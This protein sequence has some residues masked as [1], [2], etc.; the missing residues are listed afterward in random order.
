LISRAAELVVGSGARALLPDILSSHGAERVLVVASART[1]ASPWLRSLLDGFETHWFCG[2]TPNPSLEQALAGSAL[3]ERRSPDAVV[4]VGGGSAIDTAKLLRS[5]PPERDRALELL[6]GRAEPPPERPPLVALPTTAGTGSEVT[7]FATLYVDRVKASLDHSTVAPDDALVDPEL[8]RTCPAWVLWS[9]AFDA[10][11]HAAE[12]YWSRRATAES[13]ELALGALRRLVD[14]LGG[15]LEALDDEDRDV[16]ARAATAAGRAIDRARTTA[17]HAFSYSLTGRFGVPH[18]VACLLNLLWVLDCNAVS[19][20]A[21]R[22]AAALGPLQPLRSLLARG[23]FSARLRDYGVR[24]RD[25]PS[26]VQAG[27]S[28]GRATNNP[29][30]IG[31]DTARERLLALV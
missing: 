6:E 31:R 19:P 26:L 23:G 11:C 29:V 18:G 17:A 30:E 16:L 15:D 20:A 24:P 12:S 5:L 8:L 7:R 22:V 13:R 9:S 25:V 3:R 14:V 2:F 1:A 10:L 28:S 4:A 21:G 27:L